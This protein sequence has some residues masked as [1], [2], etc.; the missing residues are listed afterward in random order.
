MEIREKEF[1]DL[2]RI[3]P[4]GFRVAATISSALVSF[5]FSLLKVEH[6]P[7]FHRSL[8]EDYLFGWRLRLRWRGRER[9]GQTKR[10]M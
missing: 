2:I 8:Q 3:C 9:E 5:F 4:M 10:F 7:Q 6:L 1:A